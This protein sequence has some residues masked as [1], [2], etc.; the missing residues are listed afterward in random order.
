M[1]Y[2]Q[3]I[4]KKGKKKKNSAALHIEVLVSFK[5]TRLWIWASWFT[6]A[7]LRCQWLIFDFFF[8]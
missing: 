7:I 5:K 2:I 4:L 8:F 3:K 6:S 1:I